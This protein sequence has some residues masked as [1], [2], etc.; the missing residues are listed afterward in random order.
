MLKTLAILGDL[1]A[2]RVLEGVEGV[3][4]DSPVALWELFS[5]APPEVPNRLGVKR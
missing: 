2:C 4:T 5:S 1:G 3:L